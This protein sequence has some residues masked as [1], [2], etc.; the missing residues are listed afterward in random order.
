MP[1]GTDTHPMAANASVTLCATVNAVATF[2]TPGK[3][4]APSRRTAMNS[5]WSIPPRM[6]SNPKTMNR[7]EDDSALGS[8]ATTRSLPGSL[9]ASRA[10]SGSNTKRPVTPASS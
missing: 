5:T 1:A 8:P 4:R 2:S 6:C 9:T 3:L 7:Q 10:A